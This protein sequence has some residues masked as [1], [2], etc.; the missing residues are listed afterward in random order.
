MSAEPLSPTERAA[1]AV[2]AD[3]LATSR[4]W[5]TLAW[6][7]VLLALMGLALQSSPWGER[8]WAW[9]I[10]LL[11]VAF[12]ERYLSVRVAL[13]ARLFGRL[14]DTTL[15]SLQALDSTLLQ[16]FAARGQKTGRALAQ[17]IE[18]ARRLYRCQLVTLLPLF[19]LA[20]GAWWPY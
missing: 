11:V 13:D 15:P 19:G 6:A 9:L 14:A 8:Q 10:A 16:V 18:G 12:I 2:C 5:S 1:C 3:F 20:V 17:R 7:L 4:H